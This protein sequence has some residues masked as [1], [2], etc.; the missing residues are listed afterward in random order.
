MRQG[1]NGKTE[2]LVDYL[3]AGRSHVTGDGRR[4]RER[5]TLVRGPLVPVFCSEGAEGEREGEAE[6]LANDRDKDRGGVS[7]RSRLRG[8]WE[9]SGRGKNGLRVATRFHFPC[10][11]CK[12]GR[13][14]S[15]TLSFP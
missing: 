8:G 12:E 2:A 13:C 15:R 6:V 9:V 3:Q 1:G 14:G 7:R 5:K 10:G 11:V 4:G